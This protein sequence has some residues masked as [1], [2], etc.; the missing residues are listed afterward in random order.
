MTRLAVESF[1]VFD[2][3]NAIAHHSTLGFSVVA[4]ANIA[5]GRMLIGQIEGEHISQKLIKSGLSTMRT[6]LAEIEPYHD[7]T[8]DVFCD[9]SAPE[10]LLLSKQEFDKNNPEPQTWRNWLGKQATGNQLISFA[11][12]NVGNIVR[13]QDDP[14]VVDGVENQKREYKEK[15]NA[16]VVSGWLHPDAAQ[17]IQRIDDIKV[18]IGD[19]FDTYCADRGGYYTRGSSYVV[20][21]GE[22]SNASHTQ[23]TLRNIR[24]AA[25]H[26][27]NHAVL[28][29]FEED[30][31]LNEAVTEHIAQ[32]LKHGQ[33]KQLDPFARK[34]DD[35]IYQHERVLLRDLLKN[36]HTPIPVGMATRAYSGKQSS[37]EKEAFF[38][39][40]EESWQHTLPEGQTIMRALRAFIAEREKENKANG[41]RSV[42]AQ[43]LAV[44]DAQAA[45]LNYDKELL[46]AG[47][48]KRP[49]FFTSASF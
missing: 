45:L 34:S 20:I 3:S 13:L 36:G 39:A 29:R 33:E 10:Q 24:R 32:S 18:Y 48:K 1:E 22:Q 28:G 15:V 26:E 40:I 21:A 30:R 11:H 25:K 12:M 7:E 27:F 41:E 2:T 14:E 9:N 38:D 49:I 46:H 44:L 8:I 35:R 31:W 5:S 17:S 16:A 4:N 42:T 6:R 19:I 23:G 37:N 47:M 43:S